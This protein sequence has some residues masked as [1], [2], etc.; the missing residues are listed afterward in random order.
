MVKQFQKGY[1][2]RIWH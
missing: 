2:S 1:I